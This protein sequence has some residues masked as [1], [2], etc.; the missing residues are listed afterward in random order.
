M[1]CRGAD[2]ITRETDVGLQALSDAIDRMGGV[3]MTK[4]V[5]LVE[6]NRQGEHGG[7]Y[8]DNAIAW[9]D[10]ERQRISLPVKPVEFLSV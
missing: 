7:E 2:A 4:L 1:Y 9:D 8:M 6:C 10:S 3:P 5:C